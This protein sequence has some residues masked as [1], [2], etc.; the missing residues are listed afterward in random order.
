[1]PVDQNTVA[2]QHMMASAAGQEASKMASSLPQEK[3]TFGDLIG[4]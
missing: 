2:S 3:L 1:M 4:H